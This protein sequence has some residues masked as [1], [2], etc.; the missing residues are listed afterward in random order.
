MPAGLGDADVFLLAASPDGRWIAGNI[1]TTDTIIWDT[2]TGQPV[3]ILSGHVPF[4]GEGFARNVVALGFSPVTGLLASAGVDDT[5][6]LWDPATGQELRRFD[7]TFWV[8]LPS[9]PMAAT[10]RSQQRRRQV[11]VYGPPSP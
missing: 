7:I 4:S 3:H 2:T 6:R 8:A 5:L 1:F 11:R 10:W 9:A